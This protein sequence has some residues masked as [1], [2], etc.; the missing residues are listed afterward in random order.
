MTGM[1]EWLRRKA[2][3]IHRKRCDK[4]DCQGGPEPED[5][6]KAAQEYMRQ[7]SNGEH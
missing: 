5:W 4:P 3:E 1:P 2:R 6:E 7:E